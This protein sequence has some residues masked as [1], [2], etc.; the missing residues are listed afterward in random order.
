MRRR[1][2][3]TVA[4]A[5]ALAGLGLSAGAAGAAP[6]AVV[7]AH[8]APQAGWGTSYYAW[9]DPEDSGGVS[10]AEQAYK[11]TSDEYVHGRFRAYGEVLSIWD[12]HDNDRRS[13][14]KLW[15]G[16]SGPAVFYSKGD[17]SYREVNLSYDEGQTVHIQ[18]CTSDTSGAVCT[19]KSRV[20]GVS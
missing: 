19:E 6:A 7:P 5:L 14:V 18:T 16:G 8:L 9:N 12:Y 1:S 11:T 4:A 13:V 15:V 17:N 3:T 2:M 20:P 10:V